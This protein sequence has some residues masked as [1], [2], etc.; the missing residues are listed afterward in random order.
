[1]HAVVIS[2]LASTY[3]RMGPD[4]G[5]KMLTVAAIANVA[6]WTAQRSISITDIELDG[7]SIVEDDSVPFGAL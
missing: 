2:Q 7:V 3:S 6:R 4:V 5:R 1:M